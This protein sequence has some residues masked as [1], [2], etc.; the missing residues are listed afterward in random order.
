MKKI[1]GFTL[2]A[3]SILSTFAL[4]A[5]SNSNKTAKG[6]NSSE[7]AAVSGNEK[8][9][10]KDEA[11]TEAPNKEADT[12]VIG[13]IAPLT[14]DLSS[15][16][17]AAKQGAE[18]AVDEINAAGG[19]QV[20]DKS[21]KLELDFKD[22]EGDEQKAVTSYTALKVDGAKALIGGITSA[23]SMAVSDYSKDDYLLQISPS[24]TSA[25]VTSEPNVFRIGF[26][27]EAQ[28]QKM[29]EYVINEGYQQIVLFHNEEDEYSKAVYEAF[30]K[31]LGDKEMGGIV[32][33]DETYVKGDI[34]FAAQFMSF[35]DTEES[36]IVY[37]GYNNE[38]AALIEY[39]RNTDNDSDFI[40]ADG[41]E[42]VTE[43]VSDSAVLDGA[44]F[45]TDFLSETGG[46]RAAK[47]TSGYEKKYKTN[48]G[49]IAAAAYDAVYAVKEAAQEAGSID[50]EALV[51]AM[52]RIKFEGS[53]GNIE[54]DEAGESNHEVGLV[55][56]EGG[57]YTY[58]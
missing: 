19:V 28:G 56:L 54:F 23:S 27:D 30:K 2:A 12:L 32:V 10:N 18:Y 57:R 4:A 26:T 6:N 17:I 5:C 24:A 46:E 3:V 40:G 15:Y 11:K 36:L 50:N 58:K 22:D 51:N 55:H 37:F 16:G 48:A 13:G 45:T 25:G 29:A 42:F 7:S 52:H 14:G 9:S 43:K 33:A 31:A 39:A 34:D 8:K 49:R 1:F 44:A 41:M 21:Y 53:T 47:F 35:N 20:G 38:G